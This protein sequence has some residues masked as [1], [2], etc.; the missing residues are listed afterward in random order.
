MSD[1]NIPP[2]VIVW[3]HPN[4]RGPYMRIYE[5]TT[6]VGRDWNEI[7]SSVKQR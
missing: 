5:N 2:K 3:S 4:M 6:W 7:N 1:P